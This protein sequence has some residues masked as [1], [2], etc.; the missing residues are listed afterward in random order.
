MT[1]QLQHK[2]IGKSVKRNEDV[3]LVTGRGLYV[4]DVM[5]PGMLYGAVLRSSWPTPGSRE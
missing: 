4:G 5:L 3:R 2:Y 1:A